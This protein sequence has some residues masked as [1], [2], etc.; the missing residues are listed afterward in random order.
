M[1]QTYLWKI[2]LLSSY[3]TPWQSDTIYG[4]LFW[5]IKIL[6]GDDEFT[7]IKK[8][9]LNDNPPFIVSNGFI[10]N[11]LPFIHKNI[12]NNELIENLAEINNQNII[13][14]ATNLKKISKLKNIDF[15]TFNKL[16]Y[17][18]YSLI[19]FYKEYSNI[20]NISNEIEQSNFHNKINR[21]SGTTKEDGI[22]TT[23]EKY[24]TDDIYIYFKIREDF[25]L[26]KL[27]KLLNFI[28]ING[29]GKKA[30]TGKGA[31]KTISFDRFDGFT[32]VDGK[33]SFIVLSNYIPKENDYEYCINSIPLIKRG[34]IGNIDNLGIPFKKP[35]S[36]F[37]AGSIFRNEKNYIKG[38]V[39]ENIHHNSDII[40]IGIPF[41]V[42]VEL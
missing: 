27:E 2:Q 25:D 21:L 3:I 35:F 1:Y 37:Q 36:C 28:E 26:E 20:E 29:F 23:T 22:Y 5:G 31:F 17:K 12:I 32:K 40:Q 14:V 24:A 10:D 7:K 9:F 18:N 19:E 4:Y 39:L 30:S 15:E 6:F 16:R 38:K 8:E 42:E 11:K 13:Q 33:N 34:K 41:T